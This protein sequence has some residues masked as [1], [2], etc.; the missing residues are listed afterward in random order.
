[1]LLSFMCHQIALKQA[2]CR[3]SITLFPDAKNYLMHNDIDAMKPVTTPTVI[4]VDEGSLLSK[5]R[6]AKLASL[7]RES[8]GNLKIVVLADVNQMRPTEASESFGAF[9]E[10]ITSMHK[11]IQ[12]TEHFSS[13]SDMIKKHADYWLR[14]V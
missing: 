14:K 2:T 10:I 4:V 11:T 6:I 3:C 5:A 1:M 8:K 12:L 13:A 9:P 7:E